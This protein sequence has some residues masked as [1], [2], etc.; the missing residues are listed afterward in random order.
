MIEPSEVESFPVLYF[1][2]N[3]KLR[4]R[5]IVDRFHRD[6]GPVEGWLKKCRFELFICTVLKHTGLTNTK[7]KKTKQN[8]KNNKQQTTMQHDKNL[9][10]S[11]LSNLKLIFILS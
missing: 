7:K 8:T 6:N 11:P 9:N 10:D 5:A 3:L 2:R 4:E 1:V